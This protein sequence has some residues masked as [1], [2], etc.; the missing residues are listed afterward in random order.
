MCVVVSGCEVTGV[1][2]LGTM[3]Y[4]SC[5]KV[6]ER[7]VVGVNDSSPMREALKWWRR[8]LAGVDVTAERPAAL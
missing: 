2:D 3:T 6:S 1:N 7:E 5:V 8:V 4:V